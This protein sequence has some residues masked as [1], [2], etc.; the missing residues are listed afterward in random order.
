MGDLSPQQ[1]EVFGLRALNDI[2]PQVISQQRGIGLGHVHV[3][4]HRAK[5]KLR[6][7]LEHHWLGRGAK[8]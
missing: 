1:A 7:C 8:S 2:D 4:L 6:H 3:L 5:A